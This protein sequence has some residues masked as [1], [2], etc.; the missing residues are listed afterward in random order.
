MFYKNKVFQK[1]IFFLNKK[2]YC[3]CPAS[4]E[5]NILTILISYNGNIILNVS[6]D[7]DNTFN[8]SEFVK[9]FEE[10]M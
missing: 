4:C 3:F 6:A 8:P 5:V 7:K 9:L 1:Y 2:I 10:I